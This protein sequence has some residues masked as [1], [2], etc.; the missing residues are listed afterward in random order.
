MG[1]TC[2]QHSGMC[3]NMENVQK[4]VSENTQEIKTVAEAVIRLTVLMEEMK[5]QRDYVPPIQTLIPAKAVFWDA[6]S[7][8]LAIKLTFFAFILLVAALVGTNIIESLR[9][10]KEVIPK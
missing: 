7:K 8:K 9:V 6:D 2:N 3:V 10:V 1:E 5:K 4:T